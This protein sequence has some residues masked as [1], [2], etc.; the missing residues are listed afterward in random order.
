MTTFDFNI[1]KLNKIHIK[2]QLTVFG[3]LRNVQPIIL[4]SNIN[5]FS[6]IPSLIK[7]ICLAYYHFKAFGKVSDQVTLSGTF[8][9]VISKTSKNKTSW[10]NSSFGAEWIPSNTNNIIKWVFKC[11]EDSGDDKHN[12]FIG[13]VNNKHNLNVNYYPHNEH[14]YTQSN[15]GTRRI[16]DGYQAN[17]SITIFESIYPFFS[18]KFKELQ[19]L[20]KVEK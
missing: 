17:M 10:E 9:N 6:T 7:Y 3:Y 16:R 13:I 8:N 2:Q 5:L 12:F 18:F 15:G 4:S 14:S 11:I 20:R 19:K 1:E